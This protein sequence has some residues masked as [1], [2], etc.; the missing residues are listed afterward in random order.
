MKI[1]E[2]PEFQI[3]HVWILL[4]VLFV[5]FLIFSIIYYF[6]NLEQKIYLLFITTAKQKNF[7]IGEL[8]LFKKF[9]DYY[10]KQYSIFKRNKEIKR[11]LLLKK[12]LFEWYFKTIK[13]DKENNLLFLHI[14]RNLFFDHHTFGIAH[15]RDIEKN[16]PV[17]ILKENFFTLGFVQDVN[18]GPIPKLQ[19]LL[20]EKNVLL[21][22][23][24]DEVVLIFFRPDSGD[25]KIRGNIHYIDKNIVEVF[26]KGDF[27][28]LTF[29]L[30]TL[31]KVSGKIKIKH[32]TL[33]IETD[34]IDFISE[35]LS[36]KGMKI[37]TLIDLKELLKQLLKEKNI[38]NIIWEDFEVKVQLQLED[39]IFHLNGKI[40]DIYKM[41]KHRYLILFEYKENQ[42]NLKKILM[43]FIKN[44]FPIPEM[45]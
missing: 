28:P 34:D 31:K 26:L 43:Y 19:I 36:L 37:Y 20:F 42:N 32:K 14:L 11:P 22:S 40:K 21:K 15:I 27:E 18:E 8:E 35:K 29:N 23:N 10:R 7:K 39:Q 2:W 30:M 4:I 3:L 16:E 1:L 41:E 12:R 38:P 24:N 45:L 5:I 9:Y 25:Y 6:I 13:N 33:D 17:M 44:N